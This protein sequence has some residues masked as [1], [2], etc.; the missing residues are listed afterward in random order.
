[1][2]GPSEQEPSQANE[3]QVSFQLHRTKVTD[4]NDGGR[5][6]DAS[7]HLLSRDLVSQSASERWCIKYSVTS[8]MKQTP[9][10]C[11]SLSLSLS[12]PPAFVRVGHFK[13]KKGNSEFLIAYQQCSNH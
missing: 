10:V 6:L 9:F 7:A 13:A 3:L 8:S 11:I 12:A 1:M 4:T 2:T 5:V